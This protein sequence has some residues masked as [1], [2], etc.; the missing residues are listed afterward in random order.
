[1][2]SMYRIRLAVMLAAISA[3]VAC[4]PTSKFKAPGVSDLNILESNENARTYHADYGTTFKAALNALRQIDNARAKLVK[5]S[6]GLIIF[7]K[8]AGAGAIT[9][10]VSRAGD[11][12]T[13]VVISAKR[14]RKYWADDL[15]E[16]LQR[17][18]G[19]RPPP[20]DNLQPIRPRS[21]QSRIRPA[22]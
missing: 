20:P 8:P 15:E 19:P 7:K 5:H 17:L 2:G 14:R 6:E 22:S 3:F 4:A 18:P 11:E 12:T 21:I 1:M 16:P 9:V 10:K 13:R